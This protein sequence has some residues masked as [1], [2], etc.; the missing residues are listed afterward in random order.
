MLSHFDRKAALACFAN[1]GPLILLNNK[2]LA[3][4]ATPASVSRDRSPWWL[5][6]LHLGFLALIVLTS[7]HPAV[8]IGL[9]LLFLGTADITKE[10]QEELKLKECLLVAFFLAGLVVLGGLQGYWLKP[11]VA[12]LSETALFLGSTGLTAFTDNSALTYLGPVIPN[13]SPSFHQ[14]SAIDRWLAFFSR[15]TPTSSFDT[16]S[17][18]H[19][20]LKFHRNK[21]TA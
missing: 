17:T 11:L 1:A 21:Y 12:S 9:I 16:F 3:K 2:E 7:H 8:F 5:N 20:F 6:I 19:P 18:K 13:V 4:G 14:V 15:I 10:Y